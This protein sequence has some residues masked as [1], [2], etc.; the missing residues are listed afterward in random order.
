MFLWH[1]DEATCYHRTMTNGN[2]SSK[3]DEGRI[4][5]GSWTQLNNENL[6]QFKLDH[7]A[8]SVA[9]HHLCCLSDDDTVSF[10]PKET[11]TLWFLH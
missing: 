11:K 10:F 4:C 9:L 3:C 1:Q 5:S 7:N 2:S 8:P 6:L